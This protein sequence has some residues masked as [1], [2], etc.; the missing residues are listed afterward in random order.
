MILGQRL[1]LRDFENLGGFV[2]CEEYGLNTL[3][4]SSGRNGMGLR[5]SIVRIF[6]LVS[7]CCRCRTRRASRLFNDS[8]LVV[9]LQAR[10]GGVFPDILVDTETQ[11]DLLEA[12]CVEVG[13]CLHQQKLGFFPFFA[14]L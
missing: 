2:E 7:W 8:D 5:K 3:E 13:L 4:G 1:L 6:A 11:I 9:R 10:V 12:A 14:S